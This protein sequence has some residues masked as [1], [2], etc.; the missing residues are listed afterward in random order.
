[1]EKLVG[2]S[3]QSIANY[4]SMTRLFTNEELEHCPDVKE[5]LQQITEH[6]A[7]SL[8]RVPDFG[9]RV[10]LL[11]KIVNEKLSS[12]DL[13]NIVN[14]LRSWFFSSSQL[15]ERQASETEYFSIPSSTTTITVEPAID[16]Q[17]KQKVK[18]VLIESY[19]LAKKGDFRGIQK[20]P[21]CQSRL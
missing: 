5:C 13:A 16:Q 20:D 12:R 2:A 4:V 8:A 3:K 21:C 7:R 18:R 9:S 1:L 17:E 15:E 14:R 19:E 6:H 10:D 11:R